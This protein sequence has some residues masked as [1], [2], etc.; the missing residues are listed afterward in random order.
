MR[1]V[2]GIY[3]I[4]GCLFRD[5]PR[6]F[7]VVS[8]ILSSWLLPVLCAFVE[9]L[10]L[11]NRT[12]PILPAHTRRGERPILDVCWYIQTL[13]YAYPK[14]MYARPLRLAR[15]QEGVRIKHT[16]NRQRPARKYVQPREHPRALSF[17]ENTSWGKG[18]FV[19]G[20]RWHSGRVRVST[21]HFVVYVEEGITETRGR[22][23]RYE[24]IC[25]GATQNKSKNESKD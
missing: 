7:R 24:N 8:R 15:V 18:E 4:P 1:S 11:L 22:S 5:R 9:L 21:W 23:N 3:S 6:N 10:V 25:F 13:Q 2:S 16:K 20:E 17:S 14:I 19:F 12:F